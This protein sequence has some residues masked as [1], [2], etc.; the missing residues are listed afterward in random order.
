MY[1][2]SPS[3]FYFRRS[4]Y[5]QLTWLDL[6][7]TTNEHTSR[8]IRCLSQRLVHIYYI[9]QKMH[10]WK[11]DIFY[12]RGQRKEIIL[13]FFL[14]NTKKRRLSGLTLRNKFIH[15]V[16]NMYAHTFLVGMDKCSSA[17][18][19]IF[20]IF[21]FFFLCISTTNGRRNTFQS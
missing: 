2:R 19:R 9:S 11:C 16:Q 15:Y 6:T 13:S 8:C 10:Y 1:F 17:Y 20:W 5:D 18:V 12:C 3:N 7:W 4:S 21:C 14:Q